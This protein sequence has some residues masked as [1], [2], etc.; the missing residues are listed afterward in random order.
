MY[1]SDVSPGATAARSESFN[2]SINA[3]VAA[4]GALSVPPGNLSSIAESLRHRSDETPISELGLD[5]LGAMELCIQLELE[6]GLHV[7]PADLAVLR[8]VG[9]LL[10][11]LRHNI[12][13]D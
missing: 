5:S 7:T 6:Y 10:D 12:Q 13:L 4:L 8:S 11:M 3:V 9:E 2:T 1:L